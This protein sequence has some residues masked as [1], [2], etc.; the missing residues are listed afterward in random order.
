[1]WGMRGVGVV[2]LKGAPL[3]L[4]T[5]ATAPFRK[6]FDQECAVRC[7]LPIGGR[8]F[9]HLVVVFGLHGSDGAVQLSLNDMSPDAMLSELA[10]VVCVV[11]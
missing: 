9:M 8:R 6:F 4:P 11:S 3:S 1:M 10:V 5:I 7:S 2:S